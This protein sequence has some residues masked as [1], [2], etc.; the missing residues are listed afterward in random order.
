MY[1]RLMKRDG[2]NRASITMNS[3]PIR[4]PPRTT[5]NDFLISGPANVRM[6]FECGLASVA[7]V[8]FFVLGPLLLLVVSTPIETMG[9]W[10]WLAAGIAFFASWASLFA[11]A[12]TE[13]RRLRHWTD[14]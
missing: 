11:A 5:P 13:A 1:D 12:V 8:L 10:P 6:F 4:L 2:W 14:D 7:I 9:Q 3:R